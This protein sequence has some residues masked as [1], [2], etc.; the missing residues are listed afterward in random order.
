MMFHVVTGGLPPTPP[1]LSHHAHHLTLASTARR[2]FGRKRVYRDKP[3]TAAGY[4]WYAGACCGPQ[5]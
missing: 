5:P 4:A 3:G 2:S 1:V